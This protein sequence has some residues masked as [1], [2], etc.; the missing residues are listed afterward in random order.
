[1]EGD[2]KQVLRSLRSQQDDNKMTTKNFIALA[3]LSLPGV[4]VVA[5]AQQPRDG[6]AVL[7]RMRAAYDGQWYHT[8]TF[9]QKTSIPRADDNEVSTWYES[10]RHTPATGVQL[11]IDVGKPSPATACSTPRIRRGG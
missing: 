3:L 4:S 11:R 10:I 8:L 7:E 6:A 2:E 5:S 9:V 1:M